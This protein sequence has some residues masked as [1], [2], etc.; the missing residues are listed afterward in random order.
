MNVPGFTADATLTRSTNTDFHGRYS[1]RKSRDA[2][3]GKVVPAIPSCANCD[4]IL[5]NCTGNGWKPAT[6]CNYCAVGNCY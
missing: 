3:T 5:A 4:W 2:S 6:L 1:F